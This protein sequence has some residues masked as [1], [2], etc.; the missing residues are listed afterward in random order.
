MYSVTREEEVIARKETDIRVH[1]PAVGAVTIEIQLADKWTFTE[2]RN[3]LTTQLIG[4]YLRDRRGQAGI[5]LL[6]HR[7]VRRRTWKAGSGKAVPL[8]KM[9]EVLQSKTHVSAGWLVAIR[10]MDVSAASERR[11]LGS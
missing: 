5:H 8:N 3:G 2:L 9:T 4:Q 10:A 11:T 1:H 7:G 6:I